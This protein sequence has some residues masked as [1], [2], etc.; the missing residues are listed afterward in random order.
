[1]TKQDF[2]TATMALMV[3]VV[4]QILALKLCKLPIKAMEW[5]IL[6][7]VLVFGCITLLLRENFYLQIKTTVIN[8]LFALVLVIAEFGFKKNLMKGVLSEF[9]T[10]PDAVWRRALLMLSIMFGIIGAANLIII[11]NFSESAWVYVKT[12]GYP[13]FSFLSLLTIITY[14]MR[15]AATRDER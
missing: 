13:A 7:L 1:M 2:R 14:L 9:I 12:F 6:S 8:W 15:H 4:L 5:T 3:A 10:A 11:F